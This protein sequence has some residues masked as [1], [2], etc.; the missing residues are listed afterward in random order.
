MDIIY[1]CVVIFLFILAVTDLYVGVSN[2][3][4]NFLNSAIGSRA[5][6]FKTVITVAAVGVF[7]GAVLSNG[8]MDIARHGVFRP[9]QFNFEELMY[10][11]LAVM[12]TDIVLL[13]VFNSL[14]MP[15]STTV[16]IVFEL[17][18]ATF[19]MTIFKM[20]SGA[21]GTFA[22]YL[23][24]E[25]ALSV[26]LG[27]FLS[28]AIAFVC[29]LIIQYIARILF[30]F[31]FNKKS[32]KWKAGIFGGVAL[33]CIVYFMLIKGVKDLSFM[34]PEVSGWIHGHTWLIIGCSLVFFTVV[35]QILYFLKIN[36][37]KVIVLCGT[38]SLATAFAGNDL[39][40]FIGVPIT[41]YESYMDYMASG[42]GDPSAHMMGVLNGPAKTPLPFLIG[43]GV[44]MVFALATSKKARNVT[45][46]EINL[47]RQDEGDQ[48][49]G[50]SKVARSL[51]KSCRT[52][53]TWVDTVTPVPVRRWVDKRFDETVIDKEDGAAYDLVR[54][55]VNLMVASVL[56][57]LGTSLKLPLSTTYVTFMVAMATS[58]ADRAWS[59]E[60]AVFRVT[61]MLSV[62]GGWLVTA[63]VAFIS[64]FFLATVMHFG[65]MIV[66]AIAVIGGLAA[67]VHSNIIRKH[68]AKEQAGDKEFNAI[69]ASADNDKTWEL[70]SNYVAGNE[71]MVLD[72]LSKDYRTL[73]E[74]LFTENLRAL[75]KTNNELQLTK[76]QMKKLRK[77]ETICL[78]RL[79]SETGMVKS[80]WFHSV[81]NGMEQ[82]YYSV[83]RVSE[84]LYEH[85]DNN[86]SPVPEEYADSF[87]QYR[88]SLSSVI[89]DMSKD[90]AESR[91]V[92]LR[93]F[94]DTLRSLQKSFSDM[95]K[96]LTEDIRNNNL[97]LTMAYLYL[98]LIQ[99][100]EQM[101]I[102]VRQ[103]SRASRKFQ[104]G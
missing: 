46:T 83:R 64:A 26:I 37:F 27:I 2:D 16:S 59:R 92:E 31:H 33:T 40:N 30:T 77:K 87:R 82:L 55:S 11:L 88:D 24:T 21:G 13:D 44:V 6:K 75:R 90:C 39:V 74:G 42:V 14:G 96:S 85:V 65:G 36:V 23:N 91:F 57:A 58:L 76:S 52:A 22:D 70:F 93:S 68:E 95:R 35:M 69:L 79:D 41:G 7:F 47:T 71:A 67:L 73:T 100:S 84:S 72:M 32:L 62:I 86:F 43:A 20:N 9:E 28:V 103:L 101:V 25:K 50:T 104:L 48:M 51:V 97:N 19:A 4:V 98:N 38:F 60:S 18:G 61:G 1:L 15:T 94:D 10:I 8:M 89:S 99:E 45:Q 66:A 78:R 56:I 5:A 53:A 17:L 29:G 102:T 49:F 80:A 54:A 81:F 63:A 12:V 34:T 3:A